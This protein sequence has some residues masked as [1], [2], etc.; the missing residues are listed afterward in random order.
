MK[1]S[2]LTRELEHIKGEYGDIECSLAILENKTVTKEI[3]NIVHY[4]S[5]FII[6][7]C[8]E[9]NWEVRISTWPY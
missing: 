2:E 3:S 7:E 5:F 9:N 6:P 4:E 1:I 8:Y